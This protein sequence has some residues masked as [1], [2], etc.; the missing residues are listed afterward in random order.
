MGLGFRVYRNCI[1]FVSGVLSSV[2]GFF[3]GFCP[4]LGGVCF[5]LLLASFVGWFWKVWN[6]IGFLSK[7]LGGVGGRG[8]GV[9]CRVLRTEILP[10][11]FWVVLEVW[12]VL[13]VFCCG[14]C[15]RCSCLIL[16][17]TSCS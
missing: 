14:F 10:T 5:L 15:V 1:G 11:S 17:M 2:A 16:R 12:E 4:V 3:A 6:C 13:S 8:G 9:F 7:V